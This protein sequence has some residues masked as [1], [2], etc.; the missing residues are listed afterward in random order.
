ML[1]VKDQGKGFDMSKLK[2]PTDPENI[3]K[4]NGRGVFIVKQLMDKV[5]YNITDNGTEVLV[6]LYI[7]H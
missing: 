2:D 7:K 5:D 3:F 4:E 6:T 1:S